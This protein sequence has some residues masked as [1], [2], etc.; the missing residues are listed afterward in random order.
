MINAQTLALM[1]LTAYLI[2]IARGELIVHDDLV[3]ALRSGVIA[4][5]GLDT[6]GSR[7]SGATGKDIE[8]LSE[9]SPLW[10]LENVIITPN[11]ASATPRIYEYLA[12]IVV[13]GTRRIAAGEDPANRVV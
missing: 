12:E 13:D 10:A 4:G 3:Q 9:S 6:F 1:K 11:H 2:N 5:A 7:G 8:A